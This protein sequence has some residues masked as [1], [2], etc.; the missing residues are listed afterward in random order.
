MLRC[1]L[2]L[3]FQPVRVNLRGAHKLCL[4]QAKHKRYIATTLVVLFCL[5][6]ACTRPLC[7]TFC[8]ERSMVLQKVKFDSIFMN[9]HP[10]HYTSLVGTFVDV[11]YV[12][13]CIFCVMVAPAAYARN[14]L[15]CTDILSNVSKNS[16]WAMVR[17]KHT[18]NAHRNA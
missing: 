15:W 4:S 11:I 14:V 3:Y 6:I 16:Q 1:V 5:N 13:L 2:K 12:C 9:T 18:A 8:Q 10:T 17:C 7:V